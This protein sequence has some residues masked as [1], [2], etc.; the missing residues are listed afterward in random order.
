MGSAM[1]DLLKNKPYI[2]SDTPRPE[3]EDP[4]P[5]TDDDSDD[6]ENDPAP[7]S[8]DDESEDKNDDPLQLMEDDD[9]DDEPNDDSVPDEQLGA[10]SERDDYGPPHPNTSYY[11]SRLDQ[12]RS[13]KTEHAARSAANERDRSPTSMSL[14]PRVKSPGRRTGS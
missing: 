10:Q 8:I 3:V 14:T 5:P 11:Q 4:E 6:E 12:S 2:C 1:L 9:S 13:C 7:Q